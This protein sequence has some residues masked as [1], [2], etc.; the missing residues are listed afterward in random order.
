MTA[1]H[2]KSA[3]GW[4]T[5]SRI[6]SQPTFPDPDRFIPRARSQQSTVR[7]ESDAFTLILVPF[8]RGDTLPFG[9]THRIVLFFH[10]FPYADRTIKATRRE[11]TSGRCP[12]NRPDGLFVLSGCGS[13]ELKVGFRVIGRGPG[14]IWSERVQSEC[15]V[16]RATRKKIS[17][18]VKGHLPCG[19]S[20]TW[21]VCDEL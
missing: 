19:F 5:V 13:D 17:R 8:Q 9:L 20:V 15:L 1:I 16:R 7:A 2:S 14:G 12:G 18:R 10:L 6:S 21:E 4:T 11:C 3:S